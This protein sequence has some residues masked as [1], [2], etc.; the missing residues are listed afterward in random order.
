MIQPHR[1]VAGCADDH[2]QH[3]GLYQPAADRLNDRVAAARIAGKPLRKS[4]ERGGFLRH[5]PR[6]RGGFHH[7]REDRLVESCDFD[8]CI[9]PAAIFG[10]EKARAGSIGYIHQQFARH[11]EADV[12]L[13]AL[14]DLHAAEVFGFFIAQPQNF[15]A[16]VAGQHP[17]VGVGQQSFHAA[18]T[19]GD[20]VALLLRALIAPQDGGTDYV[21]IRIQRHK[22]VHLS[23]IGKPQNIRGIDVCLFQ[24]HLQTAHNALPPVLR[25][26]LRPIGLGRV[27]GIF[28]CRGCD[29]LSGFINHDAFCAGG[30]NVQTDQIFHGIDAPLFFVLSLGQAGNF[31][32]IQLVFFMVNQ[33]HDIAPV[34]ER[35]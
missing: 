17:V 11:A 16:G 23:G 5:A 9:A 35:G 34:A 4:G 25:I 12:I 31:A 33:P 22:T 14:E 26:L 32:K 24:N 2:A 19:F 13:R 15:A 8:Q 3:A 1:H 21:V 18:R 30:S 20:P 10:I 29:Y 6:Q 7:L 28:L 27:E